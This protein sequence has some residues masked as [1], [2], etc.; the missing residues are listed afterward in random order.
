MEV[1]A[2]DRILFENR[3]ERLKALLTAEGVPALLVSYPA[4]R[5]Y[6]SGFELH[7]SQCNESVGWLVVIASGRDALF[8]DARFT[9]AALRLWPGEDL[10]I[11][12]AGKHAMMAEFLKGRGVTSLGYDPKAVSVYDHDALREHFELAPAGGLVERL[13][14]IK[15][16]GE[17]EL[18]RAACGLNHRIM[19]ALP[20]VLQPGVTEIEA[21]WAIERMFRE[22]GAE[23]MSFPSI[24]G[25]DRNAALPHAIPGETKITR[26]CLVLVDTGCR[27]N[28]YCSDQTR[29]FWV[30]RE[31][32]ERFQ[33]TK[34]L[35]VNAQKA[36]MEVIKPGAMIAEAYHAARRVF[37]DAGVAELF[38]HS[39][40]HGI[41]LETHEG[42]S[43]GP[44][45]EGE[46]KP[47]M[48]VTVE[49]GLYDAAWGGVRWEYMVVVT[50]EGCKAL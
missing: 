37:E 17:V 46:F 10:C 43:L 47:G 33:E 42:P 14:F 16:P 48:V 1:N 4:N 7:D 24:V 21:A 49:P 20:D 40:G 9:D 3:R 41:G 34:R 6:L 32:G 13:R 22:A 31:P 45:T 44:R 19:R 18:L 8:T 2:A 35:V 30:G 38:T 28:G 26:D 23:G 25:V 15:E 29:T 11:Y 36:A 50:E 12:S 5:F 39:L 27:L